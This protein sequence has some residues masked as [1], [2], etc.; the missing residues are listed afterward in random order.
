MWGEGGIGQRGVGGG[1]DRVSVVLGEGGIGSARCGG[2]RDRSA[3]C[4]GRE[5]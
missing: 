4:G 2:G 1:R 5:G 3:G